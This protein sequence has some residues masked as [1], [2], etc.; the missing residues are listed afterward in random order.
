MGDE[1]A[2]IDIYSQ[3]F[4]V[5]WPEILGKPNDSITVTSDGK[6][7]EGI[8]TKIRWFIV[9]MEGKDCCTCL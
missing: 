4:K 7:G 3:V 6:F 9:V 8:A 5:L 2:L 1:M